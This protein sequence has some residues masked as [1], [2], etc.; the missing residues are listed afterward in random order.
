MT[1]DIPY[2]WIADNRHDFFYGQ[3]DKG[4]YYVFQLGVWAARSNVE[5]LHVD[6]S[7]LTNKAT[8][9]QIPASSF[10]CF[11][12]EGTDVT[13]VPSLKRIALWIRVKCRHYGLEPSCRSIFLQVLIKEQ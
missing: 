6:F 7:A 13:P 10:T 12:T 9:E 3:A 2:K 11:N 1:T 5:N 4:E 8:G